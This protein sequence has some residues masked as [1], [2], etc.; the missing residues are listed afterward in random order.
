MDANRDVKER[1]PP[2]DPDSPFVFSMEGGAEATPGGLAPWYWVPRWSSNE[3]LNRFQQEIPGPLRGSRPRVRLIEPAPG[4]ARFFTE[5]PPPFEPRPERWLVLPLHH[6][7][8]SEELSMHS[9]AIAQ[10]APD[11]Y[12]AVGRA[13]ADRL[14]LAVGQSVVLRMGELEKALP[15]RIHPALAEG[16]AGMPALAGI[17]LPDW[18]E[19]RPLPAVPES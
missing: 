19:I 6:C 16:T 8:G 14:G 17:P 1:P 11:P 7:L 5:P 3:A 4:A 12:L 10:R 18:G 2:R 13:A 15:V 9:Q